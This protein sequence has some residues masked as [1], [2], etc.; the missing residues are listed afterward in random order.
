MYRSFR[1]VGLLLAAL[2]CAL[3]LA[4]VVFAAAPANVNFTISPTVTP[5]VG[6][7]ITV[8]STATD[9]DIVTTEWDFD[10]DGTFNADLTDLPTD[11]SATH[12]YTTA[13][14]R[15][16]AMRVTDGLLDDGEATP[17]ISPARTVTVVAPN[18]GPTAS[19]TMSP[20]PAD[21]GQT[22]TF[23]GSSSS[24]PDGTIAS[25]DHE[26]DLDGDGQYDDASGTVVTHTYPSGGTRLIGLRVTDSDHATD[27][28]PTQTL[29]VRN[30]APTAA[31]TV[32]PNPAGAGQ[33]VTFNGSASS[34]PEGPITPTNHDWDLDGDGNFETT[35]KIV[36]RTY[37]AGT[38]VQIT[39]QVTDSNGVTDTETQTLT[40]TGGA[41]TA[42]FTVSPNP[43]R[44]GETVTL[45][46]SAS[47]DPEGPIANADHDWDLDNDGAYDDASGQIVT[48]TYNQPGAKT[49]GLRVTDSDNLTA[50]TSRTLNVNNTAP[51][52]SF[53]MSPNP[54]QVNQI[55]TFDG[56]ASNDAGDPG[57]SIA[58]YR[59]DLDGDG[60]YDDATGQTATHTYPGA[61]PFEIA[62]QVEDNN[63]AVTTSNTRV[64]RVNSPPNPS[65]TIAP[66]PAVLN[67][68]ITVNASS[69]RDFDG[70]IAAYEWD[71]DYNGSPDTFTTDAT[72]VQATTSYA[73]PGERTI[74]LRVKDNTG[75]TTVLPRE[76]MV[77]VTRPSA[78]FT[79]AP[80]APVPGQAVAFTSRSTPSNAPGN[81][82]ILST[83]WDFNYDPTKEFSPDAS[84][85]TAATSFATPGIKTVAIRVAETGGGYAIAP[86]TVNVNAPPTASFNIAPAN[87][88]EGDAVT[89]S[90]TSGDPDGPLTGH[91]WDLDGDGQYDDASGAVVSQAFFAGSHTVRLRVIDSRG[92]AATAERRINAIKRPPKLLSGVKVTLFGNLT[93]TGVQLKRLVVRTPG[94]TTVKIT[95]LG[96]KCP[97]GARAASRRTSKTQRL[98]FKKFERSF[99]AGT[100]I[101]VTV[102]RPGY[103]GQY[104]SI[105]VRSG[106][107][108]YIRRDRCILPG[109][110]KPTVCPD[111]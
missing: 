23:N 24:D 19:F 76:V 52:A 80:Q 62:L 41:P 92:A 4:Q 39:L 49:I 63:G 59:W 55:V 82:R 50:T 89:F 69:S 53:T 107:R 3:G 33:T 85:V 111:S 32:S 26:W 86:G 36:S 101:K 56:S 46:G 109:A 58:A 18:V 61:G 64:L 75:A 27:T 28:A 98:R 20:N 47:S 77:Q 94:K 10:Y 2:L 22:V 5:L 83:Q 96:A 90:S 31:F 72:G 12:T 66:N 73:I 102:T 42:S 54:A 79:F 16:I 21:A 14:S 93:R 43:A 108:R 67:E 11:D 84:G 103:I 88:F 100:L 104:T 110:K 106:L 7:Q 29:T 71:F 74:G 8:T 37:P 45:N 1:R 9:D 70:S 17:V 99:P 81:P 44:I 34:D 35:G 97:K 95:C 30:A 65:F 91:Q 38:S 78:S 48:T 87:P 13:G 6:Q 40:V 60:Q 51:T 25:A 57:G 105:R 15:D 68:T